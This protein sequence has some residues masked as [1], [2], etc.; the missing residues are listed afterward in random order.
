MDMV[1]GRPM[2][3]INCTTTAQDNDI[4][5]MGRLGAVGAGENVI[6]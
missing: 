5:Y 4:I 6:I 2:N 1:D 3:G